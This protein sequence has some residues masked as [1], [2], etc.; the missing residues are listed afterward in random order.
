MSDETNI[1]RGKIEDLHQIDFEELERELGMEAELDYY[2]LTIGKHLRQASDG[3]DGN[4]AVAVFSFIQT[5][6][7]PLPNFHSPSEPFRPM[8]LGSGTRSF[9]PDDL[10]P[11]DLEAL[12]ILSE[13]IADNVLRSRFFDF[14][15]LRT[16]NFKFAGGA[17][18]AYRGAARRF[19]DQDSWGSAA[20]CFFRALLLSAKLGRKKALFEDISSD[21]ENAVNKR[22][23]H[24]CGFASYRYMRRM[25]DFGVG[26]PSHF[27]ELSRKIADRSSADAEHRIAGHYYQVETK[28]HRLGKESDKAAEADL[29][30]A[31]ALVA[32]SLHDVNTRNNHHAAAI[33]LS[34]AIEA[35]IR[36][37]TANR[38]RIT[39]LKSTLRVYQQA[40]L[41]EFTTVHEPMDVTD[42]AMESMKIV[43]GCDFN[44]A[45]ERLAFMWNL[46]DLEDLRVR[47]LQETKTSLREFAMGMQ[48]DEDG[49][50]IRHMLSLPSEDAS[51]YEEILEQKMFE[52][53]G[54]CDWSYAVS[55]V[56]EPARRKIEEEHHPM[57]SDLE[58]LVV[59]NPF[60]PPNHE[61]IFLR[62]FHAGIHGDF[63]MSSHLLVPQIENSLRYVLERNGADVVT[64]KGNG[65]QEAKT[66]G[67]LLQ[68]PSAIKIFGACLCFELRGALTEK[69]SHDFRNRLA[70]GFASH[71]ECYGISARY[72]WWL[73][74]RICLALHLN[75][76]NRSAPSA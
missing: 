39:E 3:D 26:T 58:H 56:I 66:L 63:L 64:M 15:F 9:L 25:I 54:R 74:L 10:T 38:E 41:D 55:A 13:R 44:T 16:T 36:N 71:D 60:I 29:L 17:A 24:E 30:A 31:E 72:I 4:A 12:E 52:L 18:V 62:G 73:T 51:D 34:Q 75:G 43:S 49:K 65:L 68:L 21:L 20:T 22:A 11:R 45:L 48:R 33:K 57:L 47:T 69:A 50:P 46:I 2:P 8:A 27:A 37:G 76:T 61:M 53:A 67:S 28:W 40:T 35:M 14:L 6:L 19:D 5:L 7:S 70:H 59:N 23:D 32:D 1:F 42:A